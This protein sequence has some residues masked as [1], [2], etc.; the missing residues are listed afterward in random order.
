MRIAVV[1]DERPARSELI[2]QLLDIVPK[3]MI[4]E[5]D[6]G[7]A[8]LEMMSKDNFDLVF[9]DINLGDIEGTVLASTVKQLMPKAHIIFA[10]AYSQ[11][12]V[13]A[14]EIG[15]SN[16]ILKPFDKH[17]LE[18]IV[19]NCR[20]ELEACSKPLLNR[21]PVNCNRRIVLVDIESIVFVETDN[22]S[23][24]IHTKN[25]DLTENLSIGEYEKRLSGHRF[26]R[27][28]KSYLVNLEHVQEIFPWHNNSFALKMSG[29][30]NEILPVGREKIKDLRQ[31]LKI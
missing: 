1:D 14:F 19:A 7:T 15:V 2:H 23:C 27:I 28:H 30:E 8:A 25:G 31:I 13:R 21:L 29:Y 20:K 24:L 9:I 17:H 6:S 10:T 3:A 22:R 16:Y 4:S 5:A 26:F 18:R 12:A 11:Y